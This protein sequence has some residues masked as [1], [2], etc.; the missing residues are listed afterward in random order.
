M[1][2]GTPLNPPPFTLLPKPSTL[3]P[4]PSTLHAPRSTLHAPRST[5]HAP[6]STV[7][8]TQDTTELARTTV[9]SPCYLSPE[10][11]QGASYSY[12]SDVWSLGV[13]LYRMVSPN[14]NPNHG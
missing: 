9:G 2:R 14:P 1:R 8:V 11:V 10:I 13:I 5:L 3:L 4:Q 12:K 6:R 7:T